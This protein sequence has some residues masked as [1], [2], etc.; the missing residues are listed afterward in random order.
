M[1]Q[2]LEEKVQQFLIFFNLATSK[3]QDFP[4]PNSFSRAFQQAWEP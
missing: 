4:G 3:F 2:A 1:Y